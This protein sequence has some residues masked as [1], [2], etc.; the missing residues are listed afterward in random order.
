MSGKPAVKP[1]L[2]FEEERQLALIVYAMRA[3]G[4]ARKP[5]YYFET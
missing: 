2:G 1:P 5:V 4:S 3:E